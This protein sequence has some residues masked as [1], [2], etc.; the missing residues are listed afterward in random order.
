MI[1]YIKK[2][3]FVFI[4]N[5]THMLSPFVPQFISHVNPPMPPTLPKKIKEVYATSGIASVYGT[6]KDGFL[7][8]TMA[9]GVILSSDMMIVA[10]KT[11]PFGTLLKIINPRTGKYVIAKVM[12]RG[13]YI[14]GRVLDLNAAVADALGI[15]GLGKVEYK[16][17]SSY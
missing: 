2:V 7:G 6:K 5:T 16:R 9:S 13:P 8:K 11:L 3:M 12:D 14:T 4:S 10:H 15:T 17:V 1:R